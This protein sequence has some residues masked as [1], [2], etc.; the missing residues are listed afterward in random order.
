MPEYPE[1]HRNTL[2]NDLIGKLL[3]IAISIHDREVARGERW[4]S[5]IPIGVAF[6]A[7]IFAVVADNLQH[8]KN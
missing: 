8:G 2:P 4:K 7:G 6:I 1:G 3:D 5:W